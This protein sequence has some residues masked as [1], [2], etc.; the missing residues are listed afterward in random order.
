MP[1]SSLSRLANIISY[2]SQAYRYG[3]K[4]HRYCREI[5]RRYN[6]AHTGC[7]TTVS[8]NSEIKFSCGKLATIADGSVLVET[9]STAVL[10][11][12]VMS[13]ATTS[14]AGFAPLR[15]DYREKASATGKIPVN[16]FKRELGPSEREILASRSIDRS[17]RSSFQ[18]GMPQE[19]QIV[20]SLMSADA[21]RDTIV[22]AI[23]GGAV[24]VGYINDEV[25]INPTRVE[26]YQSKLDLVIVASAKG[27]VMLEGTASELPDAGVLKA[28]TYG[29][30]EAQNVVKAVEDFGHRY[31]KDKTNLTFYRL[32]ESIKE[33][34]YNLIGDQINDIMLD[35]SHKKLSRDRAARKVVDENFKTL[36]EMFPNADNFQ[37]SDSFSSVTKRCIT[38]NVMTKSIR[39][40][41]RGLNDLRPID[42]EINIFPALH[43]SSLFKRGESQFPPYANNEI[44]RVMENSRREIGHGTLAKNALRSVVSD[45]FPFTVRLTG[46]VLMSNGSTSMASACGGSLAL[47][48]AGVPISR[49]IAGVAMGLVANPS[50]D[51]SKFNYKILTDIAGIEDY[52]GEMD[53]KIAGSREGITSLQAD[54]K[55]T[56]VSMELIEEAIKKS[57]VARGKVLDIMYG[58]IDKPRLDVKSSAPVFDIVDVPAG[59]RFSIV[60]LGGVT[61]KGLQ[62]EYGCDIN[63]VDEDKVSIYAP[64]A[65]A[66]ANVKQRIEELMADLKEPDLK[67]SQIYTGKIVDI[68]N[69]GVMLE[70]EPNTQPILLHVSQLDHRRVSRP[71]LLGYSIG[72][73]MTVK[74]F[75]RD[76]ITNR[77]R[78]SRK[79]LLP[80][81]SSSI[82]PPNSS[83]DPKK[84]ETP[85]KDDIKGMEE[86]IGS[87]SEHEQEQ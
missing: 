56:G 22:P 35:F 20:C 15:V 12:A 74:C 16:F 70:M 9:G 30:E 45:D 84:K 69:F 72:H 36:Q 57:A 42:A 8:G 31:G 80:A 18:R 21:E 25:I 44:G 55:V 10:V 28:I 58:V 7:L 52:F 1:L 29:L 3:L 81:L 43:G 51:G 26:L 49:H 79:A 13:R 4:I 68:K 38:Q 61:I 46:Q 14:Y 62:E 63:F 32:D 86:L 17:I 75:G 77:Y 60:G 19:V 67:F 27:L 37:L 71:E 11:T 33:G 66:L 85:S 59:K 73:E 40:D 83:T 76:P 41:G 65:K 34:A 23:N 39:C 24:R 54:F 50:D 64:S 78:L 48:D 82:F 2:N 47:M 87:H 5:T 53:F 6:H